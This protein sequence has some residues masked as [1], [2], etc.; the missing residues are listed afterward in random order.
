MSEHRRRVAVLAT[1]AVSLALLASP[2]ATVAQ[3]DGAMASVSEAC[4]AANIDDLLKTPGRLTL[5]TDNPAYGP[6]WGGDPSTAPDSGWEFSYPPS[7]EGLE[8]GVA[9]GIAHALGFEDDQIDWL[10][11]IEFSLAFQPGPKPFDLHMAQISIR[12]ERA[13]N[14]DFSD[15]YFDA[16]QS[17][18]AN[19]GADITGVTGVAD[20]KGYNLGAAVGTT[21]LQ[22]IEEQIQPDNEPQVF[23]NN[24]DL[25]TAL[26][27][28]QIDGLVI[29][30]GSAFFT[31]AAQLDD[32]AI[33]GQFP[34]S[35][36]QDQIGAVLDLDSPLTACINE[37]IAAIDASGELQAI[38]D[39]TITEAQS[40]PVL[41]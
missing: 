7:G 9:Y 38:Y 1:G 8:G 23:N 14:V 25:V 17:L 24:A 18:V 33:V 39:A 37:A 16:N 6:W 11:N 2:L 5:S 19:A 27:I 13:E 36:Q 32:G 3:D 29:D 35:A 20:L 31:V 22:F 26:N 34:T 41:E 10:Q 4:Q 12:P 30:L 21:S 40:V 28:G 15:P